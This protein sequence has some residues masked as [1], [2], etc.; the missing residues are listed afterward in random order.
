MFYGAK[1]S[2]LQGTHNS[3]ASS[4]VTDGQKKMQSVTTCFINL[5]PK[6]GKDERLTPCGSGNTTRG[7]CL[8]GQLP[9]LSTSNPEM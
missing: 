3:Y 9:N 6:S 2:K 7:K 8:A 5:V 4:T 1:F